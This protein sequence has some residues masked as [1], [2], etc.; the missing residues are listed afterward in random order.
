MHEYTGSKPVRLESLLL[1]W[2]LTDIM[3]VSVKLFTSNYWFIWINSMLPLVELKRI[4]SVFSIIVQYS[5]IWL[6]FWSQAMIRICFPLKLWVLN[7]KREVERGGFCC[8]DCWFSFFKH[9]TLQG[10]LCLC[11]PINCKDLYRLKVVKW[12]GTSGRRESTLLS[13]RFSSPRV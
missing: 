13:V 4:L 7:D 5:L 10:G 8:C 3:I 9:T 1:I 12:W 2:S 6:L 11:V